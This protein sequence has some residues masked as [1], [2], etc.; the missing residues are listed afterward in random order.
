MQILK[1]RV[2]V[3]AA[4][5]ALLAAVPAFS[6]SE[7]NQGYGQA[8]VTV[9]P[10]RKGAKAP[11]VSPNQL[12]LKVDGRPTRITGW[13][14]LHNSNAPIQVVVMIDNGLRES[15]GV[16][17]GYIAHFI[18][19][20]PPNAA[21][22]VAY[23]EYES[24][25][26]VGPL[27][28]DHSKVAQELHLPNGI[29]AVSGSPYFC[30]SALANHWPSRNPF[31][32]R[33]VVMITDGVDFFYPNYNPEDPYVLTAIHDAVRARISV[34]AIYWRN[35]GVAFGYGSYDGQ[36]LLTELTAAT[37]GYSYWQGMGNPVSFQ[38]YFDNLDHRFKHQYEL[39][40]NAPMGRRPAVET[41]NLRA[42]GLDARIVAPHRVYVGHLAE[43]SAN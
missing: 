39:S 35:L 19:T 10:A 31:A 24:A 28:T 25:Q 38:P 21:V 8:V 4:A 17:M 27:S 13:K 40:F 16:Q 20:L 9:L 15:L 2:V 41:L 3:V 29:P 18:E 6:Q 42:K 34:Y 30:L 33:V 26:L 1:H 14:A 11:S 7:F 23:M 37:G 12:T 36:N 32:R 43:T 5:V 22:T